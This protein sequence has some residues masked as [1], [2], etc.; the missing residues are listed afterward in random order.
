MMTIFSK[1][2]VSEPWQELY[3]QKFLAI[4]LP[5]KK[6]EAYQYFPSLKFSEY[7]ERVE[8][9]AS[10]AQLGEN[11]GNIEFVFANGQFSADFS[12]LGGLPSKVLVLSLEEALRSSSHRSLLQ[13]R[14]NTLLKEETDPMA[15]L[16]GA[17]SEKGL[18]IY[19]PPKTEISLPI[20]FL[21]I[22]TDP[23]CVHAAPRVHIVVGADA[24]VELISS[25]EGGAIVNGYMDISLEERASVF[26]TSHS[27]QSR[28]D[29]GF[30]A[31][32]AALKKDSSFRSIIC[33]YQAKCHR[34]DYK[35]SLLGEGAKTELMGL[36]ALT[37]NGHFHAKM[38]VEHRAENCQS[39]Q[40]FKQVLSGQSRSSFTGTIFV[41]ECAQKTQAYQMSRSLLLSDG[42]I[43]YAKPNLEIFA[44][45]VKASH[46]A[47]IAQ[48]DE[49][50]RQYLQSRGIPFSTAGALLTR[51]FCQEIIEHIPH[52]WIKQKCDKGCM[53]CLS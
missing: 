44:D 36:S 52:E 3:W 22:Q 16:N 24:R 49:E 5:S 33:S 29:F 1:P 35:V 8:A 4:G 21:F 46:G 26:H 23:L 13:H 47:T 19:I 43:A 10:T 27:G 41:E 12:S 7:I 30:M 48:I 53:Q 42:A 25:I 17:C 37:E 6:S 11:K 40:T 45:D 39:Q 14:L 50:Q 9:A 31:V 15:L 2:L 51:G 20:E 34:E 28:E 32:R 18:F 38:Q